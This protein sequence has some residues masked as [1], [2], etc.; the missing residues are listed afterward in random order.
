MYLALSAMSL[1]ERHQLGRTAER[2]FRP[3]CCA[4]ALDARRR[5]RS[6]SRRRAATADR[7][8]RGPDRP[9]TQRLD[10]AA[11]RSRV[12]GAS[13]GQSSRTRSRSQPSGSGSSS[14]LGGRDHAVADRDA[15]P[16]DAIRPDPHVDVDARDVALV[17]RRR[18]RPVARRGRSRRGRSNGSSGGSTADHARDA[19]RA[20]LAVDPATTYQM[21][22]FRTRP[23][24]FEDAPRRR[25]S[26]RSYS[27]AIRV[28]LQTASDRA[29]RWG[30]GWLARNQSTG[31][32]VEA[33]DE[34][35]RPDAQ[36][37]RQRRE[38]LELGGR[39]DRARG[40]APPP[41]PGSPA[42]NRASASR[43]V[44]PVSRVR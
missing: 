25:R 8:G 2:T 36:L 12:R 43:A 14:V 23:E 26:P 39:D 15:K 13:S 11:G 28:A 34:A 31:V 6:P 19:V 22:A 9:R 21:P 37:R 7:V 33:L 18:F 5:R 3:R 42:R 35:R 32:E 24:R 29:A 30:T 38:D 40:R 27:M 41:G 16:V 17:G 44:I 4:A 20:D 1:M 10:P